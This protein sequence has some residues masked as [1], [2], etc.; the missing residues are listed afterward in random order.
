[1]QK[2]TKLFDIPNII[3][4]YEHVSDAIHILSKKISATYANSIVAVFE[5]NDKNI[6]HIYSKSAI[7]ADFCNEIIDNTTKEFCEYSGISTNLN[8][9][10]NLCFDSLENIQSIKQ[11]NLQYYLPI[12]ENDKVIGVFTIILNLKTIIENDKIYFDL[13]ANCLK[14]SFEAFDKT[15]KRNI[16]DP[17]TNLF[18]RG[19]LYSFLKN[20]WNQA[21]EENSNLGLIMLD[22]D[23]FKNINDSYG[24]H[25]GDLIIQELANLIRKITKS[26][27]IIGRYGGDE[28]IIISTNTNNEGMTNLV[29]RLLEVVRNHIFKKH[30]FPLNFTISIGY[31]STELKSIESYMDLFEFAD[32]ALYIAK[33]SGRNQHCNA[34]TILKTPI[35]KSLKRIDDDS[36]EKK[37]EMK[38]SKGNILIV[39]DEKT[40]LSLM[41]KVL[42]LCNYSVKATTNPNEILEWIQNDSNSI[43]VVISDIH[44]PIMNGLDL[45]QA[46]KDIAPNVVTIIVSAFTSRENTITALRAGAYNIVQKPFDIKEIELIVDKAVERRHINKQLESY[47]VHVSAL[48][49]EKTKELHK[50]LNII[51][52]SFDKTIEAI[53][54][55]QSIHEKNIA[56]HSMRVSLYALFLAKKMNI[57]D[58]NLL[59]AIKYAG[60]LHDLGKIGVSEKILLKPAKLTDEEMN[61]MKKHSQ[62]GYDII[63]NIPLLKVAAEIVYAHH[64]HYDGSGYPRGLKGE[65]IHIGARIFSIID[66][67]DVIISDRCYRK[68]SSLSDAF[69]EINKCSGTQF[70]PE[71][72]EIL[73]KNANNFSDFIKKNSISKK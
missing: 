17:L 58:T 45:I 68:A 39:D 42:K 35:T 21:K 12:I 28:F 56:E 13:F 3:F 50:A 18:R 69:K 67:L 43:D 29:N 60:L 30:G 37:S 59:Q 27:D 46:I 70:D 31:S 4:D 72:V 7:C 55:I 53:I 15:Y 49:K 10:Q 40:I 1:M 6:I 73:N 44:M 62:L 66:T 14:N 23:Y 54:D 51:E 24:H 33:K 5:F 26:T 38:S 19:Y 16:K 9:K 2:N 11:N 57:T 52:V 8:V 71:I 47:Q 63:K 32:K 36:A 22:I 61:I 64:E 65:K 25:A 34:N 48:L 20:S 41:S